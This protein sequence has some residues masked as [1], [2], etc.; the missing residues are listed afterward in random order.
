M[1]TRQAVIIAGGG[2][3][4]LEAMLALRALAGRR[5]HVTLL[6]PGTHFLNRPASV[7]EPFGLGGPAPT[8]F[9]DV[10]DFCGAE[11]HQATLAGVRPDEH[12]AVTAA[13]EELDYDHLVVA[14]GG[15]AADT[16][17]GAVTFSGPQSVPAITAVLDAARREEVRA[18]AFAVA[19]GVGWTLPLYELAIMT[20]VELRGRAAGV[21]LALV[22]AERAPLWLF[23]EPA[24]EAL[25]TLLADRDIRLVRGRPAA[26]IDGHLVLE[27]GELVPADRT[28]ILPPMRGP[29]IQGLPHDERGFIPVDR[30]GRVVRTPDVFAAGD[31]TSFP[32]KQGGLA[33][34]QADAAAATLAADLGAAEPMGTFRPVLRGLLLTGGAPLYLRAEL[35]PA[36]K[37]EHTTH[38]RRSLRGEVSTRALWWPPG[39]VAG[40][41]LAPY[42]ATARPPALARQPL[43]DRTASAGTGMTDDGD[44]ALELALLMADEDAAAG[45]LSQ[46]VHA[47]DAAAALRGGAL[48]V[49]AARKRDAWRAALAPVAVAG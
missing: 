38:A 23:G 26:L 21:Q 9:D 25:S 7:A 47:L 42:L 41:Y 18:I 46:A 35:S 34:Q 27:R 32:I 3:A 44:D 20:A 15:R 12:I 14:V 17:P 19:P 39:K 2:P 37:P 10:A 5:V 30:H 22:T 28:I 1:A 24:S 33:T 45:D 16:L 13:G 6:A 36:G 31:A 48:P 29:W 40:R 8:R 4:A 43:E 49:E 11:V